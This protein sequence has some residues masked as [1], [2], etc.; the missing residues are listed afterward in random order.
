MADSNAITAQ[1]DVIAQRQAELDRARE[2]YSKVLDQANSYTGSNPETKKLLQ[3][4]VQ[5]A[6]SVVNAATTNLQNAQQKLV[7]IQTIIDRE[8]V[9]PK[10]PQTE[11]ERQIAEAELDQR[12]KNKEGKC[13][14]FLTDEDCL[15]LQQTRQTVDVSKQ[16]A[17][18]AAAAQ[19][20]NA[21]YQ[22]DS[23]ALQ[24]RLKN[25]EITLEQYK[26][27]MAKLYNDAQ[28]ELQ[29]IEQ[30]NKAASTIY[31]QEV[32][33]RGQNLTNEANIRSS[34]TSRAGQCMGFIQ[35]ALP[36]MAKGTTISMDDINS[37]CTKYQDS[38]AAQDTKQIEAS[39]ARNP[40][41]APMGTLVDTA[42]G[43]NQI[44]PTT[45]QKRVPVAPGTATSLGEATDAVLDKYNE[46]KGAGGSGNWD[47]FLEHDRATGGPGDANMPASLT[48]PQPAAPPQ[49]PPQTPPETT[50]PA[51]AQE[52]AWVA[53]ARANQQS[54][55]AGGS[56]VGGITINV[57]G[58]PSTSPAAPAAPP[59]A[60]QDPNNDPDFH[61]AVSAAT[62]DL[63]NGVLDPEVADKYAVPQTQM[64]PF[65]QSIFSQMG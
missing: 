29:N 10:K 22:Q 18:T 40:E 9:P 27:D 50:A 58:Q 65:S 7:D 21:K 16:N 28:I 44:D 46:W 60:M 51:P 41:R 45:G 57:G 34:T 6:Q 52:P 20:S 49:T 4:K 55:Q 26:A 59:A 15:K 13:G 17:D 47:D 8:N 2:A 5:Q 38:I 36:Y 61:T 39:N 19:S 62:H 35:A 64:G 30:Q 43:K 12:R 11:Q 48:P 32:A 63:L 37:A 25:K 14:Y 23:L 53:Q 31:Q 56:A 3:Q 54:S 24:E 1:K 42:E 33:Q